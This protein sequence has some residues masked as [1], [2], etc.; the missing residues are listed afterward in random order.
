MVA[1]PVTINQSSIDNGRIYIDAVHKPLFGNLRLGARSKDSLGD[2]VTIEA[3][4][5]NYET[6]I[7]E[8]SAVRLSPRSSFKGYLAAVK[9]VEGDHFQLTELAPRRYRLEPAGRKAP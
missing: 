2:I 1:I 8:S 6:D 7:R 9:A 4:G 5:T 3:G